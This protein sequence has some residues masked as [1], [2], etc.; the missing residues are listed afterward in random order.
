M[1]LKLNMYQYNMAINI[2]SFISVSAEKHELVPVYQFKIVK[3][4]LN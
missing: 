1:K 4:S 3:F 2:L